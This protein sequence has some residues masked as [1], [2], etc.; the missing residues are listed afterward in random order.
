M[1]AIVFVS[2]LHFEPLDKIYTFGGYLFSLMTYHWV[3]NQINTTGATSGAGTANPS[4]APESTPVFSGVCVTGSLVLC[5]C[6]VDRCLFF[7][8]FSFG[9]CV[10]FFHIQ[11]LITPLWYLRYMDSDYPPLVSSNSSYRVFLWYQ[12]TRP[13]SVLEI[14]TV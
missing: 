14:P 7:C 1:L 13:P 2:L 5:V 3:C 12:I 6:F 9:H 11:I 8:T 10:V 4:E